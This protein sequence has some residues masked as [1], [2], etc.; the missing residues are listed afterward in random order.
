MFPFMRPSLYAVF[1]HPIEH[2][3]S[4]WIHT[5]FAQLMGIQGL[6]YKKCL[7][8]LD[9]FTS[10]LTAF[11]ERGGRGC[12]VTVPFKH[13]A[14]RLATSHTPH[15]SWAQACNTLCWDASKGQWEG[16][17]T[18]GPGLIND[19]LRHA[20]VALKD[21]R[22]LLLGAGGACAGVLAS[23]LATSPRQ[24]VV[25]NRTL[26]RAQELVDRHQEMAQALSPPI[27]L[28]ACALEET[29][30]RDVQ[31]AGFDLVINLTASSLSGQSLALPTGLVRQGGLVYDCMYGPAS[32]AF[33]D[34]GHAQGAK[35]R[36]GLGMLV[37]QAAEAFQIWHG[38][39]PPSQ[40]VLQALRLRL[41]N[42]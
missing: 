21:Q 2:S 35:G 33:L 6:V 26:E 28:K 1:G 8:P 30:L 40:T 25:A 42:R 17:N 18:D 34:W 37:E 22:L 5:Q 41:A 3:L 29:T 31:E 9:G 4:P 27:P 24:V 39:R 14:F 15:A 7:A 23:L 12:N 32:Q 16:Y 19:L 36:D 10:S 13:E 11:A 20:Q 38:P